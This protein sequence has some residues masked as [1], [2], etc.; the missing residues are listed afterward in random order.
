MFGLYLALFKGNH[1]VTKRLR[2]MLLLNLILH[3]VWLLPILIISPQINL[4]A[5]FAYTGLFPFTILVFATIS[6]KYLGAV[7][8]ALTIFV[9]GT[10]IWEFIELNT[11]IIPG[12]FDL[13]TNR[14]LLLRP[15]VF[16]AFGNTAGLLRAVGIFGHRPH[17]AGNFLAIVSTFCVALMFRQVRVKTETAA[18]SLIAVSGMLMTQSAANILAFFFGLIIILAA[19]RRKILNAKSIVT[20][21][22]ITILGTSLLLPLS[23]VIGIDPSVLWQWTKRVG[24]DAPW[25]EFIALGI[26]DISLDLLAL[27]IGHGSSFGLSKVGDISE[28]AFIKMLM[29]L[30]VLSFL[31]LITILFYP[32]WRYFFA[33]ENKRKLS[34]PYIVSLFV[35]VI[36]LWHYGS[37]LRTTNIFVLFAIYAQGLNKLA[38]NRLKPIIP[39]ANTRD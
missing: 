18:I 38:A 8:T 24:P 30:G 22:T 20:I 2:I 4:I 29:E 37:V 9:A 3:I 26:S 1:A 32:I 21:G 28:V 6:E 34:F 33:G 17:D 11:G 12:G 36:S 13:A 23:Y 39:V 7:I 25:N 35:G 19:Q 14:Q 16:E 10:V 15:G 5:S 31:T 27:I